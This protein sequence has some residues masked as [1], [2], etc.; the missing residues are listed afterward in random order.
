MAGDIGSKAT[1]PPGCAVE[2]AARW[3]SGDFTRE[4]RP[5][6]PPCVDPT[7][8]RRVIVGGYAAPFRDGVFSPKL[9]L[10][11]SLPVRAGR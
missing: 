7:R 11:R 9:P 3:R 4:D 10:T 6:R 1:R 5:L 2:A 8:W